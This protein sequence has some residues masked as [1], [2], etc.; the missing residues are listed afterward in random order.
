MSVCWEWVVDSQLW[1]AGNQAMTAVRVNQNSDVLGWTAK[2]QA[3]SHYK[4]PQ[5][6]KEL[7]IQVT[8]HAT[9]PFVTLWLLNTDY[10]SFQDF[11]SMLEYLNCHV[12]KCRKMEWGTSETDHWASYF[13]YKEDC[14][15]STKASEQL[16]RGPCEIV[17]QFPEVKI[18]LS[19]WGYRK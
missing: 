5:S 14:V 3:E 10:S 6:C 12:L 7:Q 9:V 18:K 17:F 4:A 19:I 1:V 13:C 8:I 11:S 2:L 15:I 16:L